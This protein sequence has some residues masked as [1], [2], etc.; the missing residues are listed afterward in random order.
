MSLNLPPLSRVNTATSI[1]TDG[2]VGSYS[3]NLTRVNVPQLSDPLKLPSLTTLSPSERA[4]YFGE[5]ARISFFDNY[6]QLARMRNTIGLQGDE[7]EELEALLTARTNQIEQFQYSNDAYELIE[8]AGGGKGLSIDLDEFSDD[9]ASESEYKLRTP[10]SRHASRKAMILEDGNIG[11]SIPPSPAISRQNTAR[12]GN[13]NSHNNSYSNN[14]ATSLYIDGDSSQPATA[15]SNR[16]IYTGT[17]NGRRSRVPSRGGNNNNNSSSPRRS[18][19]YKTLRSVYSRQRLDEPTSQV[20]EEEKK[21]LFD[22]LQ[23]EPSSM[24]S[25]NRPLSARSKFLIGCIRKGILP[26]ASL[27]IRKNNTTVLSLASFGIGNDLAN[28]LS[29]SIKSLPLLEGLNISD[30]NLTDQGLVPIIKSISTNKKLLFLDISRNKVD[31]E[32]AKAL[33]SF[34]SSSECNLT[35]LIMANANVDDREAA[36]FVKVILS[37]I[38]IIIIL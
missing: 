14:N 7:D 31:V 28:L 3:D 27:I 24:Q 10:Y 29:E 32:T 12:G 21:K 1:L 25:N 20:T 8:E 15:R 17:G 6:R 30:N 2:S 18:S 22:Y 11:S 37:F 4:T 26:Q 33:L 5:N 13:N 19:P 16:S 38:I 34:I 35:H 36:K 9:T 23:A